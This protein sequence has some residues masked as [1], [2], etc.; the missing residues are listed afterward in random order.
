VPTLHVIEQGAQIGK[1]GGTLIVRRRGKAMARVPLHRFDHVAV[2][3]NVQITA[4]A[5][6]LLLDRRIPVSYL[7]FSGRYLGTLLP[8]LGKNAPLRRAQC[9]RADD[10]EFCLQ[11]SR[12]FVLAKVHQQRP[13]CQRWHRDQRLE[14]GR[15]AAAEMKPWPRRIRQ[16]T[17]LDQLRGLEGLAARH[18][19]TALRAL[20]APLFAFPSRTRRPPRD[21]VSLLLGF[22]AGILR[23]RV[24]AALLQVGLD[25]YVGF[26]HGDKYGQPSLAL[27][28]MEE[29]RTTMADGCAVAMI[30]LRVIRPEHLE[31]HEGA[32]LVSEAAAEDVV[33][34]FNRRGENYVAHPVLDE[35]RPWN[36]WVDEQARWLARTI[37]GEVEEYP[38]FAYRK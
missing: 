6:R 26:L 8:P 28:L 33:W 37:L 21:P 20:V 3:G 25:P 27:D 31:E 35:K 15:E 38:A 18:Y 23:S 5:V 2:T 14:A 22:C 12:R 24:H 7:S 19:Y 13:A 16:A 11:L 30:R 17:D 1:A 4:Q 10:P 9:R 32:W 36:D 29:F 34:Q